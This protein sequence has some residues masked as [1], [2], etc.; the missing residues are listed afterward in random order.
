MT[1]GNM[2]SQ[3][4]RSLSVSCWLC[5]HGAVLPVDRWPNDA[6][7]VLRPAH[8]LHRLRDRRRRRAAQLDGAAVAG[9]PHGS[10]VVG[11][12]GAVWHRRQRYLLRVE[13]VPIVA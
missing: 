13:H 12:D 11:R 2:R 8:S 1:L 3:G 10:A 6:G 7:A 5:H 4:V 9:E